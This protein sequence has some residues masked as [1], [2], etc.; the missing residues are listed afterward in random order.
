[1]RRI[2]L[3]ALVLFATVR[4]I[5][6][7]DPI[8]SQFYMAPLQ[9]NP[10]LAGISSAPRF[11]M[12]YRNQWPFVDQSFQ[13]Y[14]TYSVAYDQFFDKFNSGIGVMILGDD[15]GNGLIKTN[16]LSLIYSYNLVLRNDM[17]IKAGI[18]ASALQ[19]RFGWDQFVFGDQLDERF[20]L[21]TPGG[22]AIPTEEV[23]P[24][25]ESTINTDISFGTVLYGPRYYA[26]ITLKH[27][28]TPDNSILG[29]NE[30]LYNGL[31]MRWSIHAGMEFPLNNKLSN[32]A[33]ITPNVLFVKQGE[34]S[35]L[36]VGAYVSINTIFAGLWYRHANTNSDAIIGSLGFKKGMYKIGYS[37]DYTISDFGIGNGG[38]HEVGIIIDVGANRKKKTVFNNCFQLFR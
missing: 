35:Q 16:K 21:N 6:A 29:I 25:D 5:D 26:G 33:F 18:E 3:I 22:T 30:N 31:P 8:Y 11:S 1:M 28:N 12:N 36:N 27:L 14:S 13:T 10:A 2:L 34:F 7:Q 32:Q 9:L 38:S 19:T 23:R 24:E 20:G 17:F 15:A 4:M 37:Y